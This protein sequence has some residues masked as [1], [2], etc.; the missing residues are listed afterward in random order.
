VP[1]IPRGL[2]RLL[3]ASAAVVL[4]TAACSGGGSDDDASGDAPV[5]HTGREGDGWT[6]LHYSMADTNLEPFM[7]A[8]VHELGVVGSN[9]NLH[10]RELI[11]RSAGYGDDELLDQGSWVG[12]RVLDLG[13]P[14][15]TEVEIGRAHV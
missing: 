13:E 14:G 7:V 4:L 8:D 6:V 2:P 9:E 11:D 5:T 1:F 3:C 12:G 15:T 10:V